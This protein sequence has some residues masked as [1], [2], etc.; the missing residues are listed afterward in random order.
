[1]TLRQLRPLITVLLFGGLALIN[2][3]QIQRINTL[4]HNIH[5]FKQSLNNQSMTQA[6]HAA[7]AAQTFNHSQ[8]EQ[9]FWLHIAQAYLTASSP[10][11]CRTALSNILSDTFS[12]SQRTQFIQ[13]L[14]Q[15]NISTQSTVEK[16]PQPSFKGFSFK[17]YLHPQHLL[18]QGQ[19][20]F[21]EQIQALILS[22]QTASIS[23]LSS[24]FNTLKKIAP[25]ALQKA[26][27][28]M[29]AQFFQ[30][31]HTPLNLLKSCI[32]T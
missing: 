30:S 20:H 18:S 24:K 11:A 27:N 9:H 15:L 22:S 32:Q 12:T 7:A 6:I 13:A 29:D 4:E 1:M 16:P 26:L 21:K 5:H 17:H 14:K 28:Q 19:A 25:D 31:R 2:F 3:W 8:G 10:A 23:T